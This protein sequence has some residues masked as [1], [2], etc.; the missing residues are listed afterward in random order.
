MATSGTSKPARHSRR[1]MIKALA[2][3][4]LLP[5]VIARGEIFDASASQTPAGQQTPPPQPS[6]LADAMT[7]LVR[8]QYGKTLSP[9]QLNEI[10]TSLAGK[11]RAR[12]RLRS[13]KLK[14]GDEPEIVFQA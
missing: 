14:N 11:L 3:V 1:R 4:P 9:E 10:K 13:F 5:A 8:I 7:E 12:E 2:T 6:P